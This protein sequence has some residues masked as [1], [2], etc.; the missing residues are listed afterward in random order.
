[1]SKPTGPE[2]ELIRIFAVTR[3]PKLAF[4]CTEAHRFNMNNFTEY[5]QTDEYRFM[6][7]IDTPSPD[8]ALRFR[9]RETLVRKYAEP[10]KVTMR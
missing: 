3:D 5:K 1:M 6:A 9:Y 10:L 7:E 2:L 8:L 4:K